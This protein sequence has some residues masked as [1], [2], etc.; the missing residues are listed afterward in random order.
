MTGIFTKDI[1]EGQ[2]QMRPS[3]MKLAKVRHPRPSQL[4]PAGSPQTMSLPTH[5]HVPLGSSFLVFLLNCL[6]H[7]VKSRFDGGDA[8]INLDWV[9]VGGSD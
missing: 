1:V 7:E 4:R 6:H 5:T 2:D 3:G 8:A 9:V